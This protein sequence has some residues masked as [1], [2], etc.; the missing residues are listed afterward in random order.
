M[1]VDLALPSP[2]L[3]SPLLPFSRLSHD[4]IPYAGP[5]QSL[6]RRLIQDSR[7]ISSKI[8]LRIASPQCVNP[9]KPGPLP[10]SHGRSSE[11]GRPCTPLHRP[12]SRSR[13]FLSHPYMPN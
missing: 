10:R 12:R 4:S 8:D 7:G 3:S 13:A 9:E 2:L 5:I 1:I 11:G 6:A